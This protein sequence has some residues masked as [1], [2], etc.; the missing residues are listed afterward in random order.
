MQIFITNI[1]DDRKYGMFENATQSAAH[2]GVPT[3]GQI[4]S[5][6]A[7]QRIDTSALFRVFRRVS[8]YHLIFI[9]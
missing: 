6:E 3:T 5:T 8:V 1:T 2:I 4:T 7:E 9:G